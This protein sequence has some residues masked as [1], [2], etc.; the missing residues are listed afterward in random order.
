MFQ[1]PSVT[2]NGIVCPGPLKGAFDGSDFRE[3]QDIFH[4]D[5]LWYVIPSTIQRT[6]TQR[7]SQC[8][9]ELLV[10]VTLHVMWT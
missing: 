1:K 9:F 4:V 6:G 2:L 3:Q 5:M 8:W 10:L 7:G